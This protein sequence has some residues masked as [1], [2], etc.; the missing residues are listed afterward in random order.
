ML[1]S[2][3][4]AMCINAFISMLLWIAMGELW[5]ISAVDEINSNIYPCMHYA[6]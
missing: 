4:A 1:K 3:Y 5:S 2:R 6:C